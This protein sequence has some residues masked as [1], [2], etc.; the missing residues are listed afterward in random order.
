[1]PRSKRPGAGGER[2][3]ECVSGALHAVSDVSDEWKETQLR[4]PS[5]LSNILAFAVVTPLHSSFVYRPL[6]NFLAFDV[7]TPLH[8]QSDKSHC[9]KNYRGSA[10][11]ER[12]FCKETQLRSTVPLSNF[13]ALAVGTQLH[14]PAR[15]TNHFVR[16][17]SRFC[18]RRK[19]FLRDSHVRKFFEVPSRKKAFFGRTPHFFETGEINA[20]AVGTPLSSQADRPLLSEKFRCSAA[21]RKVS[22]RNSPGR[23][24][25]ETGKRA[26]LFAVGTPLHS[27]ADK[28]RSDFFPG[29]HS[30]AY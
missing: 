3:G 27:Q 13:W 25:Y 28:I 21:E 4:R 7:V 15:P 8:S 2:W 9:P 14:P 6:S 24:F 16:N 26:Y 17:L 12:I 19:D 18:G 5:P 10:A 20:F 11:E 29:G 22:V 23:D 30:S 1:V